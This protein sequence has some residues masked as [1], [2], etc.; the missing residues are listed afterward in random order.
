MKAQYDLSK[1]QQG[2]F[3][4][5]DAVFHYPIYLEPDVEEFIRQ[6]AETRNMDMQTLVNEWLR[7]SIKVIQSVPITSE[8][9]PTT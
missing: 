3:Y 4:R 2:K 5:A 8:V 6:L 7:A 9:M 1:A